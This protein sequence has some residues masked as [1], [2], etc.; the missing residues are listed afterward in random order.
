MKTTRAAFFLILIILATFLLRLYFSFQAEGF[1]DD[2]SY[3][4]LRQAAEIKKGWSP[5]FNDPLSYGGRTIVF[6][7]LF[8]YLLA[9][10]SLLMPLEL[11]GRVMPNLFASLAAV[12][13]FLISR[14]LTSNKIALFASFISSFIPVFFIR[15]FN[16]VTEYSVM[17]PLILLLIFLFIRINRDAKYQ[18]FFLS[19]LLATVFMHPTAVIFIIGLL[20]FILLMKLE[21]MRVMTAEIELAIFSSLFA[22]WLYFLLFKKAF[23]LYGSSII[24]H[25]IPTSIHAGYFSDVSI[26]SMLQLIGLI[27]FLYGVYIFYKYSFKQKNRNIFLI[28]SFIIAAGILLWLKLVQFHEGLIFLGV[29]LLLLTCV[30]LKL[31]FDYLSKTK[32]HRYE[33]LF[34]ASLLLGFIATSLIP[35][36][37]YAREE[38][39]KSFS[40]DELRAF[41]WMK[42]NLPENSIVLASPE[43]GHLITAISEKRNVIDSN[44]LF[45]EDI[46][47]LFNDVSTIYTTKYETQAIDLLSEKGIT[48]IYF[49]PRIADYYGIQQISYL[50]DANCFRILYE[51]TGAGI[52]I[53]ESVCRLK[54]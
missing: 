37:V 12:P 50:H 5:I 47:R 28:M 17:V 9:F 35:T 26:L 42:W 2:R 6:T 27:P 1:N 31:F 4:A 18:L 43:E 11:A 7:P 3:W 51:E 13:V 24:W 44:Y 34:I 21:R 8:H 38:V 23:L 49:S 29:F 41:E 39:R 52:S 54:G 45:I 46:D 16:T 33:N 15:T 40:E 48:H 10:F 30:Y 25:N 53:Y 19:A 32:F 36:L 20:I 14:D 22:L